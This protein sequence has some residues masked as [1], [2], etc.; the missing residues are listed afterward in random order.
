MSSQKCIHL[1]KCDK[2]SFYQHIYDPTLM[3]SVF[4]ANNRLLPLIC[5]QCAAVVHAED[6]QGIIMST[7]SEPPTLASFNVEEQRLYS[8]SLLDN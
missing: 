6:L 7:S 3:F 5:A 8:L 1:H 2:L 4:Q